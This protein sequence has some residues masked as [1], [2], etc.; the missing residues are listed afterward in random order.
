MDNKPILEVKHLCKYFSSKNAVMKAVDDV[1]LSVEEGALHCL[2]GP[3][4]AGWSASRAAA[5][6]PRAAPSSGFTNRPPARCGLTVPGSMDSS[7]RKRQ[8]R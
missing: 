8:E 3:N 4:G 1:N 6:R 2:I 7:T 5:R